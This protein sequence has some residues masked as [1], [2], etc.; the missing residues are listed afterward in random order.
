MLALHGLLLHY[1]FLGV[2]FFAGGMYFLWPSLVLSL[3]SGV[4]YHVRVIRRATVPVTPPAAVANASTPGGGK[5]AKV[6]LFGAAAD[7]IGSLRRHPRR[8]PEV[9]TAFLARGAQ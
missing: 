2:D 1:P 3:W 5:R 9:R 6:A 8:L 4:D 7:G